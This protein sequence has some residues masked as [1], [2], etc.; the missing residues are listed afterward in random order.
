LKKKPYPSRSDTGIVAAMMTSKECRAR[1]AVAKA[2]AAS[3]SDML[4]KTHFNHMARDWNRLARMAATQE[5]L[6]AELI[7]REERGPAPPDD[8]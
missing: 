8:P 4:L 1:A 2:V 5:G 7:S 3:T 6:E